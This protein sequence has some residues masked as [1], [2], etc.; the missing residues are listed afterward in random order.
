MTKWISQSLSPTP[1]KSLILFS[2]IIHVLL[3]NHKRKI[4]KLLGFCLQILENK[5]LISFLTLKIWIFFPPKGKE[6]LYRFYFPPSLQPDLVVAFLLP[7]FPVELPLVFAGAGWEERAGKLCTPTKAGNPTAG[8]LQKTITNQYNFTSMVDM[9]MK[10]MDESYRRDTYPRRAQ[11]TPAWLWKHC[12][13]YYYVMKNVVLD[14]LPWNIGA[15]NLISCIPL[16][17]IYFSSLDLLR[18]SFSSLEIL[19]PHL[20]SSVAWNNHLL[21]TI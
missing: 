1:Q 9:E 8:I 11:Q 12:M 10:K 19:E 7:R 15:S 21:L 17:S 13:P 6:A 5:G 3:K 4:K 16:H 20:C 2:F 18:T 14:F